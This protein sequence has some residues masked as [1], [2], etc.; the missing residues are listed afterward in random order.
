MIRRADGISVYGG[1]HVGSRGTL[2][3][4]RNMGAE[5]FPEGIPGEDLEWEHAVRAAMLTRE[6]SFTERWHGGWEPWDDPVG[7]AEMLC[8]WGPAYRRLDA[9]P[10]FGRR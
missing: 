10:P 3:S 1:G 4:L 9:E 8:L 6:A 5:D 2:S 7:E